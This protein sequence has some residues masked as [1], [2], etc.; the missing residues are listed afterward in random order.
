MSSWKD[1]KFEDIHEDDFTHCF[2]AQSVAAIRAALGARR[3]LLVRGEPGVG[4]SQLAKAAAKALRRPLVSCVVTGRTEARDLHY[5]FD[6]VARLAQAQILA[7]TG[8]Q[9]GEELDLLNEQRYVQPGPLW[10][11]LNW[12]SAAEQHAKTLVKGGRPE[13]PDPAWKWK[14]E[15]GGVVLL[16]D[17]I[18][19]ADSDVPNGLLESLGNRQFSVPYFTDPV[20]CDVN[21]QPPLVIITTNEERELPAAFMRRCLVLHLALP[22]R[23]ALVDFLVGRG[24][25]HFGNRLSKRVLM[26]A[27]KQLAEERE[28]GDGDALV[29]PGQA[30]FLDLLAALLEVAAPREAD[31]LRE[32]DAI[33]GFALSKNN[34]DA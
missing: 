19:K 18:D 1:C 33:K 9:P 13:E 21:A 3:P 34:P 22:P 23:E 20:R 25:A 29:R 10:W 15:S 4:K 17:E 32:L 31:Q 30:E 28:H 12:A 5:R 27:A 11:A 26:E 14:K 16:L 2:E 8:K 24:R 6:A 7:V